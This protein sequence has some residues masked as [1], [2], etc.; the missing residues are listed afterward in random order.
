MFLY[1][2]TSMERRNG[3]M[4]RGSRNQQTARAGEYFVAA[5][6][7]H[8]GA[9][10]VTLTGNVP[11]IDVLAW[12]DQGDRRVNIQVKTRRSGSW[13]TS[14]RQGSRTEEKNDETTFWI[15]VDLSKQ[16]PEYC[17]VPDWWIRNDIHQAHEAYLERHGGQRPGNP[18]SQH[19]GIKLDRIVA[20]KDR[21]GLLDIFPRSGRTAELPY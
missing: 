9:N 2:Y 13:H 18:D 8:R 12:N 1:A 15:F 16:S 14:V 19:H 11:H 17:V 4:T 6:I 7:N 21:W 3:R 5:E 10:A 20:W